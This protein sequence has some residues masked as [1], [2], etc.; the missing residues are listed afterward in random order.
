MHSVQPTDRGVALAASHASGHPADD[1]CAHH[2]ERSVVVPAAEDQAAAAEAQIQEARNQ[3]AVA[4]GMPRS[5]HTSDV[6]GVGESAQRKFESGA[7]SVAS[8]SRQTMPDLGVVR[9]VLEFG[10]IETDCTP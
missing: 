8:Y 3:P 7:A 5:F 10:H 4:P 9:L 2:S 1:R 6:V